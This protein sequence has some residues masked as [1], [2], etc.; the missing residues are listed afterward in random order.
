MNLRQLEILRAVMRC[1]TTVDAAR[2]LGMSQPAVSN[3]VKHAESQLGFVMFDRQSNRLLPTEEAKILL[4][5]AE[6]LFAV[7]EAVLRTARDL[8]SRKRGRIRIVATAELSATLMPHVLKRFLRR[9]PDVDVTL[10]TRLLGEVVEAVE[11]GTFDVGIAIEPY[12]RPDLTL[13][14]LIKLDMMC[15]CPPDS[16]VAQRAVVT[17]EDLAHERLIGLHT[18]SRLKAMIEDAF[19]RRGETFQPNIEVRFFNICAALAAEGIG[20]AI[21][22][23]L[24]ARSPAA[25]PFVVRPFEPAIQVTLSAVTAKDRP[26]SRLV[27]AFLE[28]LSAVLAAG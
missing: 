21:V 19:R 14:P 3:A 10:D 25:V 12:G 6:P 17:P 24:T 27:R 4:A 20:V 18:T 16:A 8:R 28:D 23:S 7:H 13:T 5:E 2:E 9:D 26:Q 15:I 22:D 11:L 1:G